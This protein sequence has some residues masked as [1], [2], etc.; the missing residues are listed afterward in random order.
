MR[1]GGI[2]DERSKHD[3]QTVSERYISQN[4]DAARSRR[5][6]R[7]MQM[8]K[9]KVTR[10]ISYPNQYV[11][12]SLLREGAVTLKWLHKLDRLVSIIYKNTASMTEALHHAAKSVCI[13]PA[14]IKKLMV[15]TTNL[16]RAACAINTYI[17]QNKECGTWQLNQRA[18][19][20][21]SKARDLFKYMDKILAMERALL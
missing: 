3:H 15:V 2:Q 18:S 5:A 12:G 20:E 4:G 14:F 11:C 10:P 6:V 16:N 9:A 7:K 21:L 13:D 19:V 8:T 17:A 1:P